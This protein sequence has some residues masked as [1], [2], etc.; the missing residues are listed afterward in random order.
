MLICPTQY[1]I[2]GQ[3]LVCFI[4]YCKQKN[5]IYITLSLINLNVCLFTYY[6]IFQITILLLTWVLCVTADND[7]MVRVCAVSLKKNKNKNFSELVSITNYM[8]Y[9]QNKPKH[10][11]S[12]LLYNDHK[13]S[14]VPSAGAQIKCMLGL[15]GCPN[16]K[17]TSV[18]F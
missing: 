18:Q 2:S 8:I 12:L 13:K 17:I 11:L 16:N 10:C 4:I 7:M 3:I 9:V 6:V 5:D 14:S 15:A 1:W